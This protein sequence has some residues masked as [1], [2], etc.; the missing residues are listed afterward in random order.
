MLLRIKM[1]IKSYKIKLGSLPVLVRRRQIK[2]LHLAVLPPDGLIRVSAPE[3]MSDEAIRML[4]AMRI[5]WINKQRAKF[6]GQA[7]QT[8]RKYISGESH[9][10]WGRRYILEV[11]NENKFISVNLKGKKKIVLQVPVRSTIKKR[12]EVMLE[13]YRRELRAE[14]EKQI[15]K[16]QDKIG[17]KANNLGIM[18]LELAKKPIEFTEYVVVHELLHLIEKNHSERFVKLLSQH[19]PKWRSLKDELNRFVLTHEE[20]SNV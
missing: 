9:Y 7:R 10:L 4:L 16:W 6:Q 17:V 12:E 15:S 2:N 1:N 3:H 8:P 11:T 5:P 19:M 14:A 20:W 18:N 13:W